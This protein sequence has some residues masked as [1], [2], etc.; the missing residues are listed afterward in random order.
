M[1]TQSPDGGG[2][3]QDSQKG[4]GMP[5]V[6]CQC[7]ATYRVDE[8][9]VGRKARCKACGQVFQVAAEPDAGPIPLAGGIDLA[10]EASAAASR[11]AEQATTRSP[12]LSPGEARFEQRDEDRFPGMTTTVMPV[13]DKHTR[14]LRAVGWA[15]LF[16]TNTSNMATFVILWLLVSLEI[17]QGFAPCV[18]VI[19]V[20]IIEGWIAAFSLNVVA[21]A[22]NGEEDLPPITLLEGFFEGIVI[23]FFKYLAVRVLALAP[24]V[25]FFVLVVLST[26]QTGP[27][28]SV[29]DYIVGAVQSGGVGGLA[30]VFQGAK[31]ATFFLILAGGL[32]I[33]PILLLVVAVGGFGALVRIDLMLI[34]I[35][36]TLPGYIV[37][38]AVVWGASALA[39][40]LPAIVKLIQG[41]GAGGISAFYV[42]GAGL[43]AYTQIVAMRV[44]G[45]HY[46]H[47]KH[48]YAWDWG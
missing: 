2:N 40:G 48:R 37:C 19:G 13:A 34:T 27:G 24:A 43:R 42:V 30:G 7:G 23:P 47:Y 22:A 9:A 35:V 38:V 18:G 45:L 4:A 33:W 32:F 28:L 5:K 3:G 8:N 12:L 10:E 46:H 17:L 44:I 25:A 16:P 1:V 29:R 41:P 6:R 14:F 15:L 20:F 11:A 31:L 26:A 21:T 39:A 36:R